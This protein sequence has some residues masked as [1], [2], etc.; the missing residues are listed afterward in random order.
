MFAKPAPTAAGQSAAGDQALNSLPFTGP[1]PTTG[2]AQAVAIAPTPQAASA[3]DTGPNDTET[4]FSSLVL[5][6]MAIPG[7]L[8]MA[9]IATVLIR[10]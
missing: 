8:L 5:I 2:Q 7:F 6:A 9:L 1:P 3:A 4:L 10:R